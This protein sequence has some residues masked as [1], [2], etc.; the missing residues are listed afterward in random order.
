MKRSGILALAMLLAASPLAMA[1]G[2]ASLAE[3]DGDQVQ[4]Y[5]YGMKLDIAK[6]LEFSPRGGRC[7]VGPMRM[8]YLD[9]QGEVRVLEY[10]SGGLNC[11]R[12]RWR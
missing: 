5:R 10:R 7:E 12:G 6:V 1:K 8:K 3:L 2:V 4:Q 9:S 11:T